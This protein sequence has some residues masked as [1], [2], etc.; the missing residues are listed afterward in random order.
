MSRMVESWEVM[1]NAV[2]K[3]QQD[4]ARIEGDMR[5]MNQGVYSINGN[6]G[7]MQ[8]RMTP[9]GMMRGMMPW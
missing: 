1:A 9:M 8:N 6:V 4:V 5:I 2:H 7:T 3:M